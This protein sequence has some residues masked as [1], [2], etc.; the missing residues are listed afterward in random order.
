M[1]TYN[2]GIK[3]MQPASSN[4]TYPIPNE[5]SNDIKARIYVDFSEISDIKE[6][7]NQ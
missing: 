6:I 2:L 7:D 3:S 4:M 5:D 1:L